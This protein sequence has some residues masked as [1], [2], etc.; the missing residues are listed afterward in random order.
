[1]NTSD[2]SHPQGCEIVVPII[3]KLYIYLEPVV[4]EMP[5]ECNYVAA[6][7]TS[8]SIQVQE[9]PDEKELDTTD[10]LKSIDAIVTNNPSSTE[11]GI[12]LIGQ[13]LLEQIQAFFK[14]LLPHWLWNS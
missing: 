11:V 10:L 8:S 7:E 14:G 12:G 4:I 1:M 13:S 2:E 6:N 9:K 3:L 5:P